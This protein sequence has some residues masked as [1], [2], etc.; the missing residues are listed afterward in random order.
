V[1]ELALLH[2]VLLRAARTLLA[3]RC[4]VGT[5]SA[6]DPAH[7]PTRTLLGELSFLRVGAVVERF[8]QR[9]D[10]QCEL[11]LNSATRLERWLRGAI[12]RLVADLAGLVARPPLVSQIHKLLE[13]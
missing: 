6:C 1:D 11:A 12:P 8:E 9:R 7:L 4:A 3:E 2:P 10:L 13:T 5:V